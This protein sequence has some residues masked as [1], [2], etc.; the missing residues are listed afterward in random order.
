M[1]RCALF[2]LCGTFGWFLSL[3]QSHAQGSLFT[4]QGNLTVNNGSPVTGLFDMQFKLHPA[5]SGTNQVGSTLTNS[6]VGVTNGLFV[7]PLDFGAA[8]FN[9]NALWL[10]IGVRTNGST[11][12]YTILAPTQEITSAP[13]ATQAATAGIAKVVTGAIS[14][15]QLSTNIPQFDVGGTF[16]GP[17]TLNNGSGNFNGTLSGT[18]NGAASGTFSGTGTGNFNG[19]NTGTFIGNGAGVTNVNVTNLV[20]IVQANLNW[21]LVQ[22]TS[23]QAQVATDYLATNAGQTTLT[24]PA[25]P[26]V[27]N[28]LRLSGSGVGGWVIGQNAGQSILTGRLGLPA[29]RFWSNSSSASVA[30]HAIA[31]STNGLKMVAAVNNGTVYTSVDG[32]QTWIS[33]TSSQAWS[34]VASSAD[35]T[36]LAAAI[37]VGVIFTSTNSGTNWNAQASSL[38]SPA[39]ASIACSADATKLVAAVNNGPI[40]TSVNSGTNWTAHLTKPWI[41]VASSADGTHLAAVANNDF[42]YTSANSGTSWTT[43][44]SLGALAW[45]S[46]ASSA[47]GVHLVA[48]VNNGFI[49]TSG[50]S[51]AN[52]TQRA[53]SQAWD[54]VASTADGVNL[55]ASVNVGLVY[56]SFNGGQTWTSRTTGNQSWSAV[57]I[58][59]DGS[60]AAAA[61]NGGQIYTSPSA[62]TV[63]TGGSLTGSQFSAIEL[64]FIGNGR[65]TPLTF[66]GQFSAF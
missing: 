47:D 63:G 32:G 65:W 62:T 1:K 4:Y 3:G 36:Q 2:V 55:L 54:S 20:G 51:G 41:S 19:T 59:S 14:D 15:S 22:G 6:S 39:W 17:V 34:S 64:Q 60:R 44:S 53:T 16:T 31:T 66:T 27:G 58:S 48:A 21:Q 24:L 45:Q 43:N 10:E 29:G 52:W 46:I 61:I 26:N 49:Y 37:D 13:Y 57:A 56:S 40:Y 7:V 28:T 18:F 35:G 23:Q 9:G 11:S 33:R 25:S 12:P 38:G 8:V 5:S 50:D 42:I 30:W